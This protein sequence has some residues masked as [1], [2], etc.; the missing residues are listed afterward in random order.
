MPDI[1][2][3]VDVEVFRELINKAEKNL[4]VA[5]DNCQEFRT[6]KQSEVVKKTLFLRKDVTA[7]DML[8]KQ[9]KYHW[10]LWWYVHDYCEDLDKSHTWMII[11]RWEIEKMLDVKLD[12]VTT[13]VLTNDKINMLVKAAN[14]YGKKE[15]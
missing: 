14:I 11:N 4:I 12:G 3:Y 15:S 6:K 5:I 7:W 13:V 8:I 2:L 1:N 9:S 10:G